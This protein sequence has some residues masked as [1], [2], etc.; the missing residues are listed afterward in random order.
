MAKACEATLHGSKPYRVSDRMMPHFAT[1]N[2]RPENRDL[3][4]HSAQIKA[5]NDLAAPEALAPG[6]ADSNWRPIGRVCFADGSR[7]SQ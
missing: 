7:C 5:V 4:T 6:R 2:P 3:G 1:V